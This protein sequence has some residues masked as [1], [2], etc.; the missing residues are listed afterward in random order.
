V[1]N[2][3][4]LPLPLAHVHPIHE[5]VR[6]DHFLPGC[7]PGA[8]AIWDFLCALLDGREPRLV[9]GRLQYD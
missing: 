7:P 4:E 3:P 2:D 1:P 5:V 8:D 9:P 6:V